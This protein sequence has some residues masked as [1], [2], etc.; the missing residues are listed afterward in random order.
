MTALSGE[1][2]LHRGEG[3]NPV[4]RNEVGFAEAFGF[5][6]FGKIEHHKKEGKRKVF[7][8]KKKKQEET[9]ITRK[10]K[11]SKK[12]QKRKLKA[13]IISQYGWIVEIPIRLYLRR[14]SMQ[15]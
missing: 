15:N 13:E 4:R 14:Q 2:G 9:S 6:R 5:E 8:T 12:A 11:K 10:T 1:G 7:L 3:L